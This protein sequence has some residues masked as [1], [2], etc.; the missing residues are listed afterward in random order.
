MLR[1]TVS[2]FFCLLLF[3]CEKEPEAVSPDAIIGNWSSD[4]I[5]VTMPDGEVLLDT[6]HPYHHIGIREDRFFYYTYRTG[7]WELDHRNLKVMYGDSSF[8]D[9]IYEI[10]SVTDEKLILRSEGG[11]LQCLCPAP[12]VEPN[13]Q[14]VITETFLSED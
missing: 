7:S 11:P 1:F 12:D 6:L 8:G 5:T 4:H 2:A 10:V 9:V 14:L 13:T 3:A